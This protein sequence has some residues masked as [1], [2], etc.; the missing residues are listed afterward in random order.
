[1]S[2]LDL[3]EAQPWPVEDAV[4]EWGS[5]RAVYALGSNSR[6]RARQ[7]RALGW[8]PHRTS[9]LDWIGQM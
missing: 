6:V 1:M 2:L 9:V 3:G 5:E 4:A 7:A 8:S